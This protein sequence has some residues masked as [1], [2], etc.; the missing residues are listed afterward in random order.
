VNEIFYPAL[1]DLRAEL[2]RIRQ[3]ACMLRTN[4]SKSSA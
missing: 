3:V 1:A 4:P 2:V